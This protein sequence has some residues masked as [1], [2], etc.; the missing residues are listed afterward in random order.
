MNH[1]RPPFLFPFLFRDVVFRMPG[2]EKVLYLTF[3]DGPTPGVTTQV[4][5]VLQEY[6]AKATFFVCG[7]NVEN[8]PDLFRRICDEGHAVGNHTYNHL[9]GWKTGT[10]R[11]ITDV[12]QTRTLVQGSLFRPPYG[13]LTWRQYRYL[14]KHYRIVIWDVMCG[15]YDPAS[16]PGLC[17]ERIRRYA[18]P[19][20]VI[21]FHDSEKTTGKV[22]YILEQTLK[23]YGKRGYRFEKLK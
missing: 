7:K 13:K 15:D 8:Q 1:I 19:G 4:L 21:V 10:N 18:V 12:E 6:G 14:R 9:N 20:S 16:S 11:Y 3:D 22:P 5:D 2:A 23:D 17:Y